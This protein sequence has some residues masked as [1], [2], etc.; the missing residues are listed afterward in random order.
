VSVQ[1]VL[2]LATVTVTYTRH[3]E[4]SYEEAENREAV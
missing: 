1:Q 3:T 2:V 4:M